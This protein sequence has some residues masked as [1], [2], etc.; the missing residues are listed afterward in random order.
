MLRSLT[1][2]GLMATHVACAPTPAVAPPSA[3]PAAAATGAAAVLPPV[4]MAEAVMAR[5][6][7]V[8][9]RWDYVA[10][11]VLLAI[12]SVAERT[13]D[14]RFAEYVKTNMD[15]WV[16]PDGTIEGYRPA[17]Y[18]IDHINQ[19]K[20]L[21]A[22]YE[23]TGDERYRLAAH[24]LRD[25][26]RTH[27]RTREGGFWHK[28]IY[29]HQLWLDGIYMASPF[30]AQFA[31]V[32]DEPELYDD[33]AR[34]VL[35][36][37]RHTRDP[38]TGLFYHAWDESR[39]MPWADPRTGL[40]AN[41]WGRAM[42]WYAMAIVDVLD[43][44]PADHRDRAE[45]IRLL[46]A[47]ADAIARVQDP[48]TGLWYQVL[49]LPN[50]E[51][52]YL[53]ASASSM[54]VYSLAKGVRKG[55]LPDEYLHVARRGYQGLLDTYFRLDD[56]GLMSLHG[57]VYVGGLGGAQQRDGSFEYYMSEPVVKNDYKGVG[58]FI[59]AGLELAR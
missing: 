27:P 2:L 20:V 31:G 9:R 43:F 50:R 35:L 10:G 37:A 56:D 26:M 23:R 17:E 21:F 1:L 47:T 57:I 19:G 29:P 18:N 3:A 49:D 33:V 11:L 59:L 5:N 7:Q 44:L 42:G 14:P 16:Q 39:S 41:F 54:F 55:Y 45:I 51:G 53:E 48:V 30:L 25:Q 13:G 36:I 22:L 34:Q 8:F 6:P 12:D 58:P 28:N 46:N 32:F 24:R 40:S 4:Q 52:N 15:R 38:R